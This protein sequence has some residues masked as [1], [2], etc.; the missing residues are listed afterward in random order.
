MAIA[1]ISGN[2]LTDSG[3]STSSLVSGSGT[4]SYVPKF[5]GTSTLG[6][7]LIWDNGTNVGIGN[8]NTSYTLDVTGT[9]RFTGALSGTT[10]TFITNS[11]STIVNS[12]Q[13]TN[14]TNTNSRNMLNVTAGNVTLQFTAIHGDNV[15]ISPS[16]A[17]STYLGYNNTVQIASTGAATF[18]SSVSVG[19][20]S[21]LTFNN[22]N[23]LYSKA[24]VGLL[25]QQPDGSTAT[26]FRNSVGGTQMTITSGG[27][28]LI[29]TTTDAGYKFQVNGDI[30]QSGDSRIY[31]STTNSR[32]NGVCAELYNVANPGYGMYLQAGN[33]SNYS[34][35]VANYAA[36]VLFSV[37][38]NGNASLY[39]TLTQNASDE[40]LKN[41]IQIIPNAL[42]KISKIK[43]VT[44]TWNQDIY[45]TTRTND[46]GLIA[47]DIQSVL[48]DA[49]TLAPFDTNFKDNTSKSGENYLTVYYEKLIPLLIEGVK[50]LSQQNKELNERL[51][52]AGL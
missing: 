8:T 43:G 9:G 35:Q 12:F 31:Q 16:T 27:N 21:W 4:T 17:V 51:N 39:G 5:T 26:T 47:Q 10:A 18:S 40:R 34:L 30:Y 41:N 48:P 44:F 1:N 32:A 24:G 2:I 38:G 13:N 19:D 28:V 49:V 7:S 15:Y 14:T 22:V 52:K 29:G 6:N 33:G 50:E 23:T 3:V 42:D 20:G 45:P 36:T 25:I 11:N 46:I 37:F